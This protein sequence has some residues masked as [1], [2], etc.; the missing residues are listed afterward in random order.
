MS[1]F[2]NWALGGPSIFSVGIID[3]KTEG[4]SPPMNSY[5][6]SG[7]ATYYHPP[8]VTTV[9]LKE[10]A[11]VDASILENLRS[12][13]NIP[14]PIFYLVESNGKSAIRVGDY[15]TSS[16][17]LTDYIIVNS[18]GYLCTF[19]LKIK[20]ASPLQYIVCPDMKVDHLE[21]KLDVAE[22]VMSRQIV[23]CKK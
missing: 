20:T 11:T 15:S 4:G 23:I 18:L 2:L 9:S 14:F 19:N 17:Y 5:E 8:E 13:M 1:Y 22:K 12:Y 21:L 6:Y 7:H 10:C 3:I 16:N